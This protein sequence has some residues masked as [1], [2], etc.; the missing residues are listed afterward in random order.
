MTM[1]KLLA[2][3][4]LFCTCPAFSPVVIAAGPEP[5]GAVPSGRWA[6]NDNV[7]TTGSK[8]GAKFFLD[9][10]VADDG[11]FKGTWE[12]YVCFNYTGAYGIVTVACQRSRKPNAAS[13]R[14]DHAARAGKIDLKGLGSSSF[15]FRTGTSQKGEPQLDLEL[16][17]QW[18][19]QDAPVLYEASLNPRSK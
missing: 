16:A 4:F 8:T 11:S 18:L 1:T 13:G 12:Q 2:A 10:A 9:I 14:L 19:K 7:A 17:R 6:S 3:A 5:A 15:T